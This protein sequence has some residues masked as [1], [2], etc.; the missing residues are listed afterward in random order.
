MLYSDNS[1]AHNTGA[2]YSTHANFTPL[3]AYT[4]KSFRRLCR[5]LPHLPG[6]SNRLQQLPCKYRDKLCLFGTT[7][8]KKAGLE[9]NR[10]KY[11]FLISGQL[12]NS[13]SPVRAKQN[14]KL[15]MQ[16]AHLLGNSRKQGNKHLAEPTGRGCH[17]LSTHH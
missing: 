2:C 15:L 11:H 5:F 9:E 7:N 13:H 8:W 3:S 12:L 14:Y 1:Q 6:K 17:Q 4:S 10:Y 16:A